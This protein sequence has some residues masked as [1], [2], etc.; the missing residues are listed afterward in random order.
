MFV[1]TDPLQKIPRNKSQIP[2]K[3]QI[4]NTNLRAET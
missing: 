1:V 3:F 4:I 2:N